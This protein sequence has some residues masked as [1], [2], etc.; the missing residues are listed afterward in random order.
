MR[1]NAATGARAGGAV[2]SDGLLRAILAEKDTDAVRILSALGVDISALSREIDTLRDGNRTK[3]EAPS[4]LAGMPRLAKFGHDLTAAARE[5]RLDP[6]IGR[7]EETARVVSILSRRVKN[8]PCL[9]GE[10]GVGKT[11]IAEGL[12]GRIVR[13]TV[14]TELRDAAVIAL[15]LSSMIAGAKYRG[16]FEDRLRGVLDEV[17]AAGNVI[18]FIDEIHMI[19]GAGSA[20]GAVDAANIMKP[21]LS[22]G[23]IRV[24][25]ATTPKEYRASI[26]KDAA[27]SRRFAPVFVKEP[28]EKEALAV[29]R[30]LKG[31]Y[32]AH[33]GLTFSEEALTAAVSLSVRYLPERFLPDKAIDLLDEAAAERRALRLAP[34]ISLRTEGE[35]ERIELASEENVIT[36]G[37][38]ARVLTRQTGIPASTLTTDDSARLASLESALKELLIGQDAAAHAL[39]CALLRRRAGFGSLD[40]PLGSFLFLGE[41]G[42]GKTAMCKALATHLFGGREGLIR[43]DMSEYMEKHSISRLIGSPP[44]YVGYGEGGLLTE[45]IRRHPYSVVLFDEIEKAHPDV[46]NLMLQVME[47]GRLTDSEGHT[48]D[49]RNA[50][51]VF[52]SNA[53][54]GHAPHIRGFAE[55]NNATGDKETLRSAFR[56]EFLS[57]LDEIIHFSPL[58]ERELTEIAASMLEALSS[59]ARTG[60]LSLTIGETVA[61]YLAKIAARE[62]DGARGVRRMLTRKIEDGLVA[63]LLTQNADRKGGFHIDIRDGVPVFTAT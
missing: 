54:T 8:N 23:E 30:G 61:P 15:D 9:I 4:V 29:L 28:S 41:T 44:G 62:G 51:I 50:I 33:H 24:F 46:L 26:E 35:E 34:P 43:F 56:P 63:A 36:D 3:V 59:R 55:S 52:T 42:V 18:L 49:F 20:E 16:E 40:R 32:E 60:G 48:A 12:A 39:C 27:L 10:P 57:R 13:G 45:G 31:R 21:A 19:V 2:G 5:G 53:G 1:E 6:L 22:R 47:E 37:D 38:V 25:G 14:P 7:E 58:G 11:A 17:R